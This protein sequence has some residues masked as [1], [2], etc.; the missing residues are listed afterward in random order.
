MKL[1]SNAHPGG[2]GGIYESS[3]FPWPGLNKGLAWWALAPEF[4]ARVVHAGLQRVFF[5][6]V[7]VSVQASVHC[8]SSPLD[9]HVAHVARMHMHVSALRCKAEPWDNSTGSILRCLV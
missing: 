4:A 8:K 5:A 9:G 1:L 3:K 2:Y 6:G 7:A